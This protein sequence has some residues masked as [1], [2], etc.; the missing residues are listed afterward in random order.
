MLL[1]LL[2]LL[3]LFIIVIIII[4]TITIIIIIVVI[5]YIYAYSCTYVCVYLMVGVAGRQ[6]FVITTILGHTPCLALPLS[7]LREGWVGGCKDPVA[8]ALRHGIGLTPTPLTHTHT[9][10]HHVDTLAEGPFTREMTP[11]VT[12]ETHTHTPSRPHLPCV[13]G[14]GEGELSGARGCCQGVAVPRY[15]EQGRGEARRREGGGGCM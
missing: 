3:L 6:V 13:G 7:P 8:A 14:G 5:I 10:T 4:I 15:E 12:L 11:P 9:H 2:L 1:L